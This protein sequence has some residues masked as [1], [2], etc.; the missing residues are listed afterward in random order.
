MMEELTCGNCKE[1][2]IDPMMGAV[3]VGCKLTGLVIPHRMNGTE[4]TIT[5]WRIPDSC[6]LTEGVKKSRGIVSREFWVVKKF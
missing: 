4:R 6:P 2:Q 1:V 5:Y 3:I